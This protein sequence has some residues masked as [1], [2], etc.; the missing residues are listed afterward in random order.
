MILSARIIG[1]DILLNDTLASFKLSP[2]RREIY[3]KFNETWVNYN[4][5]TVTPVSPSP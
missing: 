3:F 5:I 2:R 4:S 1:I